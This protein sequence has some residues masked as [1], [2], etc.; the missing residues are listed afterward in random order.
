MR[1]QVKKNDRSGEN[2][3]FHYLKHPIKSL[4]FAVFTFL[5]MY[6]GRRKSRK[7]VKENDVIGQNEER[8]KNIKTEG[9]KLKKQLNKCFLYA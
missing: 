6:L 9:K 1:L 7:N 2:S 5:N 4:I 8:T 3:Y